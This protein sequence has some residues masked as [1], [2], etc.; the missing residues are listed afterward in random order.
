MNAHGVALY[1]DM[2]LTIAYVQALNVE[3]ANRWHNGDFNNWSALEWCGALCGEAGELANV[4][5]KIRRLETDAAGN[6]WS[7]RP[8]DID[9][10]DEQFASECA[11]VFLYLTLC[12]SRRGI[13]LATA[14][15]EK[16]NSKSEQMGF[17]E[18]L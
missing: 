12:A 13:N 1:N 4:A 17:P 7:D 14:V 16:F 6:A 9:A 8:L 11:D 2:A 18:R 3:R 5:K 15:R 10:L